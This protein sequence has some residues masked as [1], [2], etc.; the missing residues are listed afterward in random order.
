MT[1]QIIIPR[2]GPNGWGARQPERVIHIPV[3]TRELWLHHTAGNE[4]GKAGMREIQNYHMDV[5]GWSDIAYSFVVD[6]DD[7]TVYEGRGFGI[8]GAHT[9][10]HNSISHAICVMGNFD[11]E[12]PEYATLQTIANLI[13]FGAERGQWLELTGGHR[14]ASGAQTACPGKYLYEEIPTIRAL[15]QQPV[16]PTPDPE[17]P[18]VESDP[19]MDC[20][21]GVYQDENGK[22]YTQFWITAN[23]VRYLEIAESTAKGLSTDF[24]GQPGTGV[25][26]RKIS[27]GYYNALTKSEDAVKMG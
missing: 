4:R 8:A 18:L 20:F 23:G 11:V 3:P 9:K 13:N 14:D 19:D 15:Q 1:D 12:I 24:M 7:Q 5:K 25:P 17:I 26:Q 10:D 27:M 21:I 16:P 6:N 22:T 2:N